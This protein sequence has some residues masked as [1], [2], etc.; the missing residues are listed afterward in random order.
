MSNVFKK[1][2]A[3]RRMHPNLPW[4]E[5]ISRASKKTRSTGH[6]RKK[7][8]GVRETKRTSAV[9]KLRTAHRKE[10]EIIRSLGSVS[11]STALSHARNKLKEEI[12]WMEAAKFSAPKKSTKRKIAK[13]IAEKK[14]LYNK[15][16]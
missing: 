1:A 13:R 3:I 14:A 5:C 16:K 9:R 12:G 4:Q 11:V 7:V 2:K 10:G 8:S 6:R 15:L